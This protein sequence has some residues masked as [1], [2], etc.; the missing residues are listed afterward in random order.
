MTGTVVEAFGDFDGLTGDERRHER[1]VHPSAHDG[2]PLT[3]PGIL[4]IG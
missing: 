1:H 4:E 3:A 2:A